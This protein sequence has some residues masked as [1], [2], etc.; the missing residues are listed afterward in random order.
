MRPNGRCTQPQTV[1]IPR[2]KLYGFGLFKRELEKITFRMYLKLLEG[3]MFNSKLKFKLIIVTRGRALED[4]IDGNCIQVGTADGDQS[5]EPTF[6]DSIPEFDCEAPGANI[7][8][9]NLFRVSDITAYEVNDDNS[10]V[11]IDVPYDEETGSQIINDY[12][13][14]E[15]RRKAAEKGKLYRFNQTRKCRCKVHGTTANLTMNGIITTANGKTILGNEYILKTSENNVTCILNKQYSNSN[16][17]TL[18][19]LTNNFTKGFTVNNQEASIENNSTLDLYM[20]NENKILCS[21]EGGISTSSSGL[22]G[23]AIAGTIVACVVGIVVIGVIIFIVSKG[24]IAKG[25]IAGANY[26]ATPNL[27]QTY[28]GNLTAD[29]LGSYST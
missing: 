16:D 22:S 17:S 13:D 3:M 25:A 11:N 23:G 1:A 14:D 21:E 7:P 18:I 8:E 19:C 4:N 2:F 6:L 20:A 27:T 9:N 24:M 28:R 10:G 26:N 12:T 15:I 5:D 29:K